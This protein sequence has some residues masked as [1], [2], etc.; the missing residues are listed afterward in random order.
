MSNDEG[1]EVQPTRLSSKLLDALLSGA[2]RS[3]TNVEASRNSN[4]DFP[5]RAKLTEMFR[6][7]GELPAK[8]E[9]AEVYRKLST[10][11]AIRLPAIIQADAW[12]AYLSPRLYS[13]ARTLMELGILHS[14]QSGFDWQKSQASLVMLFS[15]FGLAPW[16]DIARFFTCKGKHLTANSLKNQ[17]RFVTVKPPRDWHEILGALPDLKD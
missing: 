15:K 5:S 17:V 13:C 7:L 3:E 12:L 4:M 11:G 16:Q 10:P 1:N 8:R 2:S 14:T 9:A 6:A